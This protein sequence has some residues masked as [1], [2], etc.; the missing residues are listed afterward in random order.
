MMKKKF[1]PNWYE[2]RQIGIVNKKIKLYIKIVLL[3]NIILLSFII[4][5][6]NEIKNTDR[7]IGTKNKTIS[8]IKAGKKDAS[9]IDKYKELSKFFEDNNVSYKNIIITKDNF[10]IDIVVNNYDEYINVIRNIEEHYSI[11]K[12]TPPNIKNEGTFNFNVII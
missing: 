3:V 8:I 6:S 11:K 2:D 10:E 4:N 9:I 12:L 1:I 5:I 7:K